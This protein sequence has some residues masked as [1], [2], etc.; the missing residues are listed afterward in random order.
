[1]E[2]ALTPARWRICIRKDCSSV[3]GGISHSKI[4]SLLLL[5]FTVML[6]LSPPRLAQG[7]IIIVIHGSQATTVTTTTSNATS[8]NGTSATSSSGLWDLFIPVL[9]IGVGASLTVIAAAVVAIRRRHARLAPAAQL[10]CPRCRTPIS[11]Y[12]VACRRCRTPLY[13]PYRYYRQRR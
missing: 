6:L 11:P 5:A 4:A 10:I 13:H 7:E 3:S 8:T 9:I 2:R 12:D 1:L